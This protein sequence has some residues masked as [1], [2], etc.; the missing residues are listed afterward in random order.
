M[1]T[2]VMMMIMIV[3]TMISLPQFVQSLPSQLLNS[4]CALLTI[5]VLLSLSS[6]AHK[7]TLTAVSKRTMIP[8]IRGRLELKKSVAFSVMKSQ[9]GI[10]VSQHFGLT[11]WAVECYGYSKEWGNKIAGRLELE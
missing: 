10:E 3:M 6:R 7:A 4:S 2:M 8:S 11:Y 5:S 1:I 9:S